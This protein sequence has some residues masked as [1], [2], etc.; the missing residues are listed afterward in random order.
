MQLF[1]S[2]MTTGDIVVTLADDKSNSEAFLNTDDM[3][4]TCS[5]ITF[6]VYSDNEKLDGEQ[7]SEADILAALKAYH[8]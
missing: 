5:S 4:I 6:A 7:F 3:G 2:N 8:K 1:K